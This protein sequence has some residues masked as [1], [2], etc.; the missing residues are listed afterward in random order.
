L[1]FKLYA[2]SCFSF[3]FFGSDYPALAQFGAQLFC[4]ENATAC[5]FVKSEDINFG[6]MLTLAGKKNTGVEAG[7]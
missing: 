7:P 6:Y 4:K 5:S 2:H 3:V 1:V